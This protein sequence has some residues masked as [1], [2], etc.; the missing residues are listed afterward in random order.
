MMRK[1]ASAFLLLAFI[2]A[3]TDTNDNK[4]ETREIEWISVE[5]DS[6]EFW[7]FYTDA[8]FVPLENTLEGMLYYVPKLVAT[9]NCFYVLDVTESGQR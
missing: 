3:C 8:T 5:R 6:A 9:D 7:D 1:I 2:A 4:Y